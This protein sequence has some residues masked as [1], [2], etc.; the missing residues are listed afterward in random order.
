MSLIEKGLGH[1][2]GSRVLI[3][4]ADDAVSVSVLELP[5]GGI[6]SVHTQSMVERVKPHSDSILNDLEV[7]DHLVFVEVVGLDREL[8]LPGV[9]VRE[10]ALIRMLREHVAVLD[11]DGLADAVGHGLWGE[12]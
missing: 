8:H 1:Q 4:E 7:T 12:V 11:V 5:V 10:L 6:C 2:F 3:F 9:S